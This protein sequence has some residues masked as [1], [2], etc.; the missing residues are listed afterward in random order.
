MMMWY[1]FSTLLFTVGEQT[2]DDGFSAA[3]A[4]RLYY[5]RDSSD[6]VAVYA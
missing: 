4:K 5:R 6:E 2:D 3:S 1:C